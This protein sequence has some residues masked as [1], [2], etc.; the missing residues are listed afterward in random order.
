MLSALARRAGFASI[1][2]ASI[3]ATLA[4][5]QRW[6]AQADEP[7][8]LPLTIIHGTLFY[9]IDEDGAFAPQVP[10]EVPLAG[11]K[12]QIQS[13]GNTFVTF[14]DAEGRYEFHRDQN[15]AAHLLTSIAP[16]PGFVGAVGGRWLATSPNPVEV[17]ANVPDIQVDFG[18]LAFVNTPELARSKGYWS[19]QG[20]AELAA[21]DPLWR[22]LVNDL[23]LRTNVSNPNGQ[24]GTFFSVS[25]SAPFA[26]AFSQLAGYLVAPAKGVLANIL[27]VQ[28]AAANLNHACGALQMTTYVDRLGDDV[29]VSL[30]SM[31][32]AT[33]ALLCDPKSANTGPHGDPEWRAVIMGCLMEWATLNSNGAS[34]FTPNEVPSEYVSPY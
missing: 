5:P 31:I 17:I 33:R 29:L 30:D 8:D 15:G 14:T 25:T 27:S 34:I 1:G 28:F 18:N 2:A 24:A 16:P 10:G 4:L 26:T 22:E 21:C 9:D 11:W 12:V 23:C 3:A 20:M 19:N 32:E 13:M 6:H 7:G